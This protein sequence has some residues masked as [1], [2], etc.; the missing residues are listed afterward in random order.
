MVRQLSKVPWFRHLPNQLTLARI[1]AVPILLMI[2]PIQISVTNVICAFIFAAAGITDILDGYLARKYDQETQM[3]ALLDPVA[4]KMLAGACLLLL[5]SSKAMP[6]LMCGILLCRDIA[7]SGMRLIAA[8]SGHTIKVSSVGKLKTIF[9]DVGIFSLMIGSDYFNIP[10][11]L[12][13][14]IS[15]WIA[16]AVSLF[17][18]YQYFSEFLNISEKKREY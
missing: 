12:V 8:E 5:A 4:D 1:V 14:I 10:F 6:V 17:S 13:G 18:G 15:I 7:V 9:Q 2:Y 16:M 11:Y 3:G